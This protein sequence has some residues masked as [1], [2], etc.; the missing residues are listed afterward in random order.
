[1]SKLSFIVVLATLAAA[2]V[3]AQTA[4]PDLRGTWKG[5]SET[6][7]LGEGNRI[8]PRPHRPSRGSTVSRSR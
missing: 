1:M 8:T 3:A 4:L 5:D 6:I 7:I 2:P